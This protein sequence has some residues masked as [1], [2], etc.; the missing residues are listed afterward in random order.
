MNRKKKHHPLPRK[1]D[2]TLL[3]PHYFSVT[4]AA[5]M[6]T[7]HTRA[8]AVSNGMVAVQFNWYIRMQRRSE[9]NS[10][11][12]K[13][14]RWDGGVCVLGGV[15][16][17]GLVGTRSRKTSS[18]G[19]VAWWRGGVAWRGVASMSVAWCPELTRRPPWLPT[20]SSP[21]IRSAPCRRK[22]RRA[23]CVRRRRKRLGAQ[24]PSSSR[25]PSARS[26][27]GSCGHR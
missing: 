26:G 14:C 8:R 21:K 27:P 9:R 22:T 19:V 23:P 7:R 5:K 12:Q 20:R 1:H 11:S 3:P 13:L 16:W 18:S 17:R 2:D 15:W 6:H 4:K 24:R 25:W 10:G